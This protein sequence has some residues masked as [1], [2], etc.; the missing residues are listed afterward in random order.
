L[1]EHINGSGPG[2]S[3]EE[4]NFSSGAQSDIDE[5][6]V[7]GGLLGAG[8]GCSAVGDVAGAMAITLGRVQEVGDHGFGSSESALPGGSGERSVVARVGGVEGSETAGVADVG[9]SSRASRRV[10]FGG[11]AQA[12]VGDSCGVAVDLVSRAVR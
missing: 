9:E 7:A 5:V 8:E 12:G 1:V 4:R 3:F 10:G 6:V 11:I 2:I